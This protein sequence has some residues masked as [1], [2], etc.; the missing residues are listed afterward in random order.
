MSLNPVNWNA[1]T[2]TFKSVCRRWVNPMVRDEAELAR[3]S[4][5]FIF[6]FSLPLIA[7]ATS[8][9]SLA[10]GSTLS[11][12]LFSLSIA[13]PVLAASWLSLSGT[14]N[15]SNA[16]TGAGGAMLVLATSGS[17]VAVSVGAAAAVAVCLYRSRE[18][19][20]DRQ[21]WLVSALGAIASALMV[22][23]FHPADMDIGALVP[24]LPVVAMAIFAGRTK[25]EQ[26]S[27]SP[28]TRR[29]SLDLSVLTALACHTRSMFVFVQQNG[30]VTKAA[31]QFPAYQLNS[32]DL[33]GRGLIECVH[34][35]D[36]PLFLAWI[37]GLAASG[38]CEEL[39]LRLNVA[40]VGQPSSFA[41]CRFKKILTDSNGWMVSIVAQDASP[42]RQQAADTLA[43]GSLGHELRT[44]LTAIVGFSEMLRD[45]FCGPLTSGKQTEYLDLI[46]RSS[47]H[48]LQVADAMLDWSQLENQ[49]RQLQSGLF[50][51]AQTASLAIAIV[52]AEA[53]AKGI[54]LDFDPACGLDEFCGD[55][56][57]FTQIL[58]N[59]LANA[60]KFVP[61][62]GL[63]RLS[64]E[65][66]G[67]CLKLMV[68]DNGPGM[69]ALGH[70]RI[71]V[72]FSQ[73]P[74]PKGAGLSGAG[75]GLSI[76]RELARL[77][78]GSMQIESGTGEGTKV[79][80][81]LRSLV[82]N[83]SNVTVLRSTEQDESVR[84]IRILEERSHATHSKTA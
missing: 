33:Q 70:S 78:G 46:N 75:L 19:Q 11:A 10:T 83:P 45:G 43:I 18:R 81:A 58:V 65:V 15:V 84:V 35:A 27:P 32:A 71:A 24:A 34:L 2:R 76:V 54:H 66:E 25:Q 53:K 31:G 36:R 55:E 9:L 56:R 8:S 26:T 59:L 39:E 21:F 7:V 69:G 47:R 67:G 28:D 80:V 38:P 20:E 63:I 62:N 68:A 52:S 30:L 72:P 74:S 48:L 82:A 49:A 40:P 16:I 73:G 77:H 14:R 50:L 51:P 13:L 1:L 4:G 41:K 17:A 22:H 29:D 61:E 64:V 23:A 6:L 5:L 44:P 57:A 3:Q 79:K 12:T 37:G 42:A 60:V